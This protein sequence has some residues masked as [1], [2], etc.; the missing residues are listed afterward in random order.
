MN[1]QN[2]SL[3]PSQTGRTDD[4]IDHNT[5][6]L[7]AHYTTDARTSRHDA[8]FYALGNILQFN[9]LGTGSRS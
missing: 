4:E 6:H 8:D 5:T 3:T 7:A 1:L 2:S 9:A